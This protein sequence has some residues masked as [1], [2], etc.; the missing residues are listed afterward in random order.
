[1]IASEKHIDDSTMVE[2]R[3]F[4]DLKEGDVILSPEGKKVTVTRAYDHHVPVSMYEVEVWDGSTV[5]ASGN[6]LWYVETG[7]DRSY[8]QLRKKRAKK[9]LSTLSY[10]TISD[11]FELATHHD[12]KD[13][14]YAEL[15][16]GDLLGL[17]NRS[18]DPDMMDVFSRIALSLGH[19]VEET[20]R[21]VALDTGQ[22]VSSDII[23]LYDTKAFCQQVLSLTGRKIYTKVWKPVIG[24]V[25]TTEEMLELSK[26]DEVDIPDAPRNKVLQGTQ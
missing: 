12:V 10:D 21:N 26:S 9:V 2:M 11:F 25:V 22:E 17:T 23:P 16:L 8:H 19:I 20:V 15:S 4:G 14:E 13:S 7:I 5:K 3:R 18:D 1:M 6:H 24:R